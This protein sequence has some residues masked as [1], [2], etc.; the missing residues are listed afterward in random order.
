MPANPLFP[1]VPPVLQCA[2]VIGF[3]LLGFRTHPGPAAATYEV[4]RVQ[5]LQ[6]PLLLAST[7]WLALASS[8]LATAANLLATTHRGGAAL[9]LLSEMEE[10]EPYPAGSTRSSTS[11]SRP[12]LY[13]LVPTVGF[14]PGLPSPLPTVPPHPEVLLF[15]AGLTGRILTTATNLPG[16]K[17]YF[18]AV[19]GS[20]LETWVSLTLDNTLFSLLNCLSL[21][22]HWSLPTRGGHTFLL[23]RPDL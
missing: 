21:H 19:P 10:N 17:L 22:G 16:E 2:T 4:P 11:S 12:G 20:P 7:W 14:G 13:T 18:R 9:E 8:I 5:G 1:L 6:S 15:P 3:L 23:C